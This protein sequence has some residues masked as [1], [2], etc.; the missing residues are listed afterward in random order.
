MS[1]LPR[2]LS[3]AKTLS[4]RKPVFLMYIAKLYQKAFQRPSCTQ[5]PSQQGTRIL[6]CT[7]VKAHT[8]VLHSFYISRDM[9]FVPWKFF[10]SVFFCVHFNEQ[11]TSQFTVPKAYYRFL[12]KYVCCSFP[13]GPQQEAGLVM[14][15]HAL[16][17][18]C[19]VTVAFKVRS[20]I[21][22]LNICPLPPPFPQLQLAYYF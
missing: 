13:M 6:D 22:G 11:N 3:I 4:I 8:C 9:L 15:A 5:T 20:S 1:P 2:F 14:K 19:L 12:S 21:A 16:P 10:Q 17:F 7:I 18:S